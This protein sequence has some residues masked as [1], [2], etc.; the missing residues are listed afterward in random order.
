M[1]LIPT[2]RLR[3]SSLITQSLA[4]Q[5]RKGAAALAGL[6]KVLGAAALTD[7]GGDALQVPAAC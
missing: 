3:N 2:S 1:T 6:S 7:R 4:M 5:G